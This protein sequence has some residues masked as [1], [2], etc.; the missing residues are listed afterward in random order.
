MTNTFPRLVCCGL[1]YTHLNA[2]T[3][4]HTTKVRGSAQRNKALNWLRTNMRSTRMC[5][6][7]FFADDGTTYHLEL[8]DELYTYSRETFKMLPFD[9]VKMRQ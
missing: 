3:L 2:P 9:V 5:G 8:F 6:V 7:V 4:P 1:P